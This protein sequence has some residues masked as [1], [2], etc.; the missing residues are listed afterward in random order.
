MQIIRLN[1][2]DST[3]SFSL[4]YSMYYFEEDQEKFNLCG[5]KHKTSEDKYILIMDLQIKP[6][7]LVKQ[8]F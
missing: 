7:L 8:R 5:F 3:I 1:K 6:A 4:P 2:V